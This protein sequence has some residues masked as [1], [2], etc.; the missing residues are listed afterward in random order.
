MVSCVDASQIDFKRQI[1][2]QKL[3]KDLYKVIYI[4]LYIYIYIYI[5]EML[6]FKITR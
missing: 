6:T 4:Y 2:F 5:R 1:G 3:M